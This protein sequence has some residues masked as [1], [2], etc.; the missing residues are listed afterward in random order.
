MET[1]AGMGGGPIIEIKN[2]EAFLVGL[3]SFGLRNA[4]EKGGIKLT[5][6]I[7]SEFNEKMGKPECELTVGTSL[8]TKTNS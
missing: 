7:K 1:S 5:G 8:P 2:G 4:G 6:A 3:H